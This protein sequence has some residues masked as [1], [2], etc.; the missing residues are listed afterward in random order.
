MIQTNSL[1]TLWENEER[2]NAKIKALEGKI[3]RLEIQKQ[4]LN[5][6][7]KTPQIPFDSTPLFVELK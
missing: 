2:N 7:K 5:Y 4:I 1:S 6:F 3:G